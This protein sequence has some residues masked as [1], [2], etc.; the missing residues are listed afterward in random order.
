MGR[1]TSQVRWPAARRA[2]VGSDAANSTRRRC[3]VASEAHGTCPRRVRT[4]VV[5]PTDS[6]RRGIPTPTLFSRTRLTLSYAE[7]E[8]VLPAGPALF[9]LA[10]ECCCPRLPAGE[11]EVVKG[12]ILVMQL[13]R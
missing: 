8:H 4:L 13:D 7:F 11:H 9:R 5:V 1:A 6:P 10:E 12:D 3:R 2:D